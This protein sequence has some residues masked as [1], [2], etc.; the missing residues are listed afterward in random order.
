MY[1]VTAVNHA[2][3]TLSPGDAKVVRKHQHGINPKISE[4]ILNRKIKIEDSVYHNVIE[5]L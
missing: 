4:S 3:G 1:S 5:G 2:V